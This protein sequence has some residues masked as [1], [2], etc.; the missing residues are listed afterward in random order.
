MVACPECGGEYERLGQHWHY[1]SS[2]RP[3]LTQKQLEITTG[4]L[5]GDGYISNNSKNCCLVTEMI[6]QNYLQYLDD[7]F[8][9]LGTGVSLKRNAAE[10]AK[11]NR[12]S[13][14]NKTAKEK[15]Y[16]DTYLW[17]TRNHPKFNEF[18]EWYSSGEKV[19]PKDIE[20]TPTVLKHL[21]VGD[22]CYSNTGKN[23]NIKITISNEV[24]NIEKVTEYFINVGLPKPS[25]YSIYE[26]KVGGKKM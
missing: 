18:R 3:K 26:R 13:G 1:S 20:L 4:L 24:K 22:G 8:N 14:F 11:K 10:S 23:N 7:V 21:Y 9:C 5:M 6:S 25:N 19:W 2:H 15:N 12:D 16:S 17:K